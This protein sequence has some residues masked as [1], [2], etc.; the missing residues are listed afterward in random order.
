MI[1]ILWSY[2]SW[3]FHIMIILPGQKLCKHALFVESLAQGHHYSRLHLKVSAAS[4][5]HN[6]AD[7]VTLCDLSHWVA[8][9]AHLDACGPLH[10]CCWRHCTKFCHTLLTLS[11]SHSHWTLQALL[12]TPANQPTP[13]K[14]LHCVLCF[15][16]SV[17]PICVQV[18]F[19]AI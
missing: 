18:I 17:K 9:H 3:S 4:N 12:D 14:E 5:H 7:R 10:I 11:I 16:N 2:Q 19:R 1:I 15:A 6:I 13:Y 8:L